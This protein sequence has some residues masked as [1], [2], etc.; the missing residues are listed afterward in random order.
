VDKSAHIITDEHRGY[1]GIDKHFAS[2][3]TVNHSETFVRGLIFHTN[4]A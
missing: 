1:T 3:H 2:H 4:F